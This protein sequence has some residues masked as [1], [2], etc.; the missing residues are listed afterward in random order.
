MFA[1]R[2]FLVGAAGCLAAVVLLSRF[3]NPPALAQNASKADSAPSTSPPWD[4]ASLGQPAPEPA[5]R[6]LPINLPTA[7]KLANVRALDIAIASERLAV[8][9]AQLEQAK[10]LWLPTVTLGGDYNRHDGKIQDIQGK[11]LDVSRSSMM[12]GVGSGIGSAA[13]FNITDAIFTPLAA[14]Q[15]VASRA[16]DQQA[17]A[18]DVV[19]AVSDAYWNA[20]QARGELAGI[21]DT[22]RRTEDLVQR[23]S[24]LA[25]G[26]IPPLEL[27]RAEAELARRQE[28]A[29][30]AQERWRIASADLMRVLWLNP[31]AQIEPL[32][33]PHL[34]V[35]VVDPNCSVDDLI[36]TALTYRPE[37]A[38]QQAQV[39]ATLIQL[40]QEKLRP[41]IPSVLLRGWSTPVT[42]TLGVGVFGGGSNSSMSNFGGRED[43]DL[44]VL[45]Q[46]D[47]LGFGNVG[48]IHQRDAEVR[49]AKA[50][51]F[52]IQDRVATEVAQSYVRVTMALR[53][54]EVAQRE[55]QLAVDSAEKNLV[56]LSQTRRAGELIQLVVR[57]QE[58]VASIQALAQAYTDYYTAVADFNR[59]QFRLYRDI[60]Q[61]AQCI[62]FNA[63]L[64]A[65]IAPPA[66]PLPITAE[67]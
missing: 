65:P 33:P 40:R 10:V 57:P 41:L 38:S 46:F 64:G 14:C 32:E 7:L 44:Q 53:R 15:I 45:W 8:A 29:L 54:L 23:V 18:N 11:I 2:S 58:V 60:G 34:R 42:G 35:T 61:P 13:V 3:P 20:Q 43:I 22:V 48:R 12:Y 19:V 67:R 47:N 4:P 52:R 66:S 59:A 30:R 26:L 55:V 6:P 16:A 36:A 39:Q 9:V 27:V 51:L 25:E 62:S 50:E 24:K 1:S 5:N 56:G 28:T 21:Q 63:P 49:V 31:T 17:A 37:L